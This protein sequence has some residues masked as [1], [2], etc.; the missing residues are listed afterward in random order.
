[1]TVTGPEQVKQIDIP[2]VGSV[3]VLVNVTAPTLTVVRPAPGKANGTAML[4][5][6]GGGFAALAWDHEGLEIAR[7]LAD[8]GVTAFVVKYRVGKVELPA[9]PPPKTAADFLRQVLEPGRQVALTDV[10]QAMRL[11]RGRASAY[12]IDPHRVG[13]IG[14]SAGAI[15]TMGVLLEAEPAD[16]PDFAVPVYGMIAAERPIADNAPPLFIVAAQDDATVPVEGSTH[17]FELWSKAKRPA[18]LHV[19][20]KGG[21]G[22]GARAKGPAEGWMPALE[23]WLASHGLLSAP[24]ARA[25]P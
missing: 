1:V 17:I 11:V 24:P 3:G 15:T 16:R 21:H 14:F 10:S 19:Y 22:F 23:A 6:P 4:V 25:A 9:G 8:R 20:E 13:V 18:E 5:L 2:G 12:A 7:W